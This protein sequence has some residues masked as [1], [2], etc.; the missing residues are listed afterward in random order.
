MLQN[1]DLAD[2]VP[3]FITVGDREIAVID[4]KALRVLQDKAARYDALDT[5]PST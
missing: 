5:P 1:V 2:G 4:A 3:M